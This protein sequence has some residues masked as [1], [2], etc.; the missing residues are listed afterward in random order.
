L[1]NF[2]IRV[3]AQASDHEKL[4]FFPAL[5]SQNVS[6]ATSGQT[7]TLRWSSLVVDFFDDV[8]DSFNA[9]LWI[10]EDIFYQYQYL[11]SGK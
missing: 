9:D 7:I 2:I 5:P 1:L 8:L 3:H 6:S 11:T 10:V 4:W